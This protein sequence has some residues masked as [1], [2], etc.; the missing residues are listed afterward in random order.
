MSKSLMQ[1][2]RELPIARKIVAITMLTSS[3]ALILAGAAF[4]SYDLITFRQMV[5]RELLSVAKIIGFN[6]RA[7][8]QFNDPKA[9]EG[10]LSALDIRDNVVAACIYT[11]D[12][13]VFAT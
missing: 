4:I 3:I 13:K 11:P 1:R 9:A 7:A 12:G 5:A 2:L 8:V 6:S 10:T